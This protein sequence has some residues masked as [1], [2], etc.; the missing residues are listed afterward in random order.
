MLAWKG[1]HG[2]HTGS[3]QDVALSG[4]ND[5]RKPSHGHG[6]ASVSNLR[7]WNETEMNMPRLGQPLL[8]ACL[9][10]VT[11]FA[12]SAAWSQTPPSAVGPVL[13]LFQSGRLPAERQPPV[14]EMICKRGNEH[15]LRVVYDKI[16]AA[17]GFSAELRKQALGW[18]TDAAVTRKIKPA[19][20][21]SDLGELVAGEAADESPDLQRA[22]IGL[23]AAC[24]LTEVSPALQKLAM[25]TKAAPELQRAAING[26]VVI[27]DPGSRAT[28]AKLAEKDQPLP[29]RMQAVAGL[30]GSDLPA[31]AKAAAAVLKDADSKANLDAMLDAFFVQKGGAEAL[32]SAIKA[33]PPTGDVAKVAL[34]YMYSVGQSDA[35]LSNVLSEIAGIAADPPPPTQ[36]EVAAIVEEVLAK[37]D[38]VRGEAVFRRKDISCMKCHSISRAG[39]QVGPDLSAVGGSS[40]TDYIVNSILNPNLAVKELYVTK[41]FELSSGKVLT[42]VVIDRD[43]VRVNLRDVNGQTVTIPTAD[44]EDEIEGRSLM[45]QGLTKFLTHD[46]L[47]DLARYVSEL[48]KP[49]TPFAMNTAATI[50]RWRVL[51]NPPAELTK[52]VPHLE[53]V[54]QFI[55]GSDP[56]QWTPAYGKVDGTLP[57]N[58]LRTGTGPE[59]VILKGEFN[60]RTAGEVQL[61]ITTN[62]TAQAWVDENAFDTQRTFAV[63]LTAGTHALILRLELGNEPDPALRVE[64]KSPETSSAKFEI[65]GGY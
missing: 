27:G 40:P 64:L 15:D 35:A 4:W 23:A 30:V 61:Q 29:I 62:V 13:K 49:E 14:V 18:L 34:R 51:L 65:I 21:L 58:E 2:F 50:Q 10:T 55:L 44:I 28:L 24:K 6:W 56:G 63:P 47:I 25:S 11:L 41:V 20:D 22:A 36:E 43:D 53:N 48:G 9:L 42:G 57:L 32:A 39:G 54:R 19:G 52:D 37:G 46:E 8:I 33:N 31:A 26:L 7:C 59:V 3:N 16:I 1:E 60:V 5:L 45:P 38:P 12:P 17:D